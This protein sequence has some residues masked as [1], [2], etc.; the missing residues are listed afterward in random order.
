MTAKIRPPVDDRPTAADVR[1]VSGD[2]LDWKISAI[3][4]TGASIDEV[5]AALA[6]AAGADDVMGEL[7]RPLTGNVAAVYDILAADDDDGLEER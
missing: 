2:I 3:V 4:N 5:E 1:R 7:R 6:W